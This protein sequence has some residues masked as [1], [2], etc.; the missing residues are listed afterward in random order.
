[1]RK[2]DDGLEIAVGLRKQ[3]ACGTRGSL[4]F[5]GDSWGDYPGCDLVQVLEQEGYRVDSLARRGSTLEDL[6][7]DE[8]NDAHF[9]RIFARCWGEGRQP[10]AV[11]VSAGGNDL[12]G[13]TLAAMLYHRRSGLG[14]ISRMAAQGVLTDRLHA[15]YRTLCYAITAHCRFHWQTYIPILVHGYGYAVPDGRGYLGGGWV[16]PG[17][18]LKPA[19]DQ[20][21]WLNVGDNAVVV[22]SLVD[23][24]NST[25][26]TLPATEG[27]GHVRHV[28]LRSVLVAPDYRQLWADELHPTPEGFRLAGKVLRGFLGEVPE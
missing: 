27:L 11:I 21:G 24:I 5:L 16:L 20:K 1:V 13:A 14:P 6:V 18:W 2:D 4:I 3:L 10:K 25:I 12:T 17:P 19:F 9:G 15:Y 7:F 22:S 8:S 26:A 28:D 23:Q